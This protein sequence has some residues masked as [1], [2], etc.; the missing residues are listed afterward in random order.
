MLL[1]AL[2]TRLALFEHHRDPMTWKQLFASFQDL[3]LIS[4]KNPW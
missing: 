4:S 2:G 3:T 1:R